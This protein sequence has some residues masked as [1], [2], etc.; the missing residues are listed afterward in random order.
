ML[1]NTTSAPQTATL[2]NLGNATL[3]ITSISLTGANAGSFTLNNGCRATLA[4][5]R[6]CTLTVRF[7]PTLTGP[8]TAA[9]S[10]STNDPIN[11]ALTV[12]LSGTGASPIATVTPLILPFGNVTRGTLSGPLTVTMSNTGTVPLTFT[13]NGFALG[14][15]NSDQFTLTAG[16]AVVCQ[17]RDRG[18]GGSCTVIV[19]FS[20]TA[21]TARGAKSA[22]LIIRD[23][24]VGTPVPSLTGTAQ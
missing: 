10:I 23:N 20:P 2:S 14:G 5:G 22:T 9:V 1:V 4:A 21:N 19:K 15:A 7:R 6:S 8:M 12:A 17:W 24:A 18:S 3:N 11:P 16:G 13:A